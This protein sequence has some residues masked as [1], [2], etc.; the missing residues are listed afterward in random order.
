[1]LSPWG[2]RCGEVMRWLTEHQNRMISDSDYHKNAAIW[3]YLNRC[4]QQLKTIA[5][6]LDMGAIVTHCD[7][8]I[9]TINA[10]RQ[11]LVERQ[12]GEL[13]SRFEDEL[14]SHHF[15][16]I[17]QGRFAHYMQPVA[18]G[19]EVTTKFPT[20]SADIEEAGNC[21]AVGRN[22]ACVFHLMRVMEIG[23]RAL[24]DGG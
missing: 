6:E 5:Q 13:V 21:Y 3:A 15:F 24:A 10:G 16:Y 7:R 2:Y 11:N 23:I 22:T 4:V 20:A 14:K 12:V 17:P 18:F 1:M 19:V 8:T 9:L